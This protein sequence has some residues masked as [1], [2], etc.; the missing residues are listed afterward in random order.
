VALLSLVMAAAWTGPLDHQARQQVDD[1]LKRAL[2]SY[3]VARTLNAGISV[4]QG[5]ALSAQPL[6]VGLTLTPGQMLDPLNDLVEQFSALMLGASIAFGIQLLLLE[7]SLHWGVS[8]LL[9]L[10]AILWASHWL[11][12]HSSIWSG[13][14]L[15]A[16]LL[17]RF[18]VPLAG[19]GSG[20]A[21]QG[22]MHT[23]FLDGQR[24]VETASRA[25]HLLAPSENAGTKWWQLGK[26]AEKFNLQEQLEHLQLK[27]DQ[28]IEHAIRLAVIFL[29]QTLLLPLAVMWVLLRAGRALTLPAGG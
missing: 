11:R 23:Q 18:I 27:L 14:L 19:A 16:L 26:Q 4:A 7:M 28:A 3:A 10:G 8:L 13:K 25:V 29:L 1:G 24:A 9:S 15:I 5:T 12:G 20:L 17:L 6:G 21:Y 2:A 22:F